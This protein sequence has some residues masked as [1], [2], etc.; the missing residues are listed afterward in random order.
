MLR[1]GSWY[2]GGGRR[3]RSAFRDHRAPDARGDGIGFRLSLGH[4]ELRH[5]QASGAGKAEQPAAPGADGDVAEQSQAVPGGDGRGWLG[6]LFGKK[7]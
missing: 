1:G 3:V 4:A 5:G 7:L 2:Y 6:K